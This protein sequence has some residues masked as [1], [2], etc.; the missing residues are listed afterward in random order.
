MMLD[1]GL[2]AGLG[3]GALEFAVPLAG[4]CSSIYFMLRSLYH[5]QCP[6]RTAENTYYRGRNSCQYYWGS[7][8]FLL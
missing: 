4:Y 3:E 7:S 5:Q 6:T 8:L 2:P 1:A